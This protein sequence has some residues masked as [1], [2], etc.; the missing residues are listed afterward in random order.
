MKKLSICTTFFLYCFS[1]C[2]LFGQEQTATKIDLPQLTVEQKV[3]RAMM[4][5]IS[6]MMMGLSYAKSV[7]KTPE[8]FAKHSVKMVAPFYERMKG[9]SPLAFL[10]AMYTV[11]QTDKN[12]KMEIIESSESSVKARMSLYG[13]NVI[14]ASLPFGD[15]TIEDC[16]SFYNKFVGGLTDIIGFDYTYKIEDEQ[17][18]F[19]LSK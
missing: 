9:R 6:Y 1:V 5:S 17:I 8:E 14:K 19:T 16:Y 18:V 11:Q 7:G 13:I 15:V 12:F 3:D 4:N 10:Q 2:N